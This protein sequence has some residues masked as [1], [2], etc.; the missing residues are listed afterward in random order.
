MAD[1]LQTFLDDYFREN[2]INR[3]D[4]GVRYM[5]FA[6]TEADSDE[7]LANTLSGKKT[8]GFGVKQWYDIHMAQITP[9]GK[10]LVITDYHGVANAV[11]RVVRFETVA[12]KNFTP[13]MSAAIGLGD[14]SL[15]TWRVK[16]H[17][18]IE[19]DCEETGVEFNDDMELVVFWFEMLYPQ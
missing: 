10:I 18:L 9:I 1:E 8:A 2:S 6:Y 12:Y 16:R 7:D 15:E 17:N 5:Y 3:S 14:G 11:V 13:E 19:R 4:A